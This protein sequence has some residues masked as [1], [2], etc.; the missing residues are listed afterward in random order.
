[1]TMPVRKPA[2]YQDILDL[3][4]HLNGEIINGELVAS[5]RPGPTH[6]WVS[7][8]LGSDVGSAFHRRPGNPQGPGGWWIIDEPE[9]HLGPHVLIPDLAGWRREKMP[10]RPSTAWIELVPDWTCEVVSPR[11]AG[12]DRVAKARIYLESGV[13]WYWVVDPG[14]GIVEVFKNAVEQWILIGMWS[15]DDAEARIP[16][17]DA[18]P[19]D[20]T[21]WWEGIPPREDY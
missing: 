18:V 13:P 21:R 8:A 19:F 16:P 15:D 10:A 9:L 3:P 4:E 14:S 2:T 17:F 11:S 5:P 7:S 20:L 12:R 6:A 1:M